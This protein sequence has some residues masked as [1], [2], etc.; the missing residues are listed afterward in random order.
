MFES[1]RVVGVWPQRTTARLSKG[2]IVCDRNCCVYSLSWPSLQVI[3]R[4]CS[5]LISCFEIERFSGMEKVSR[6]LCLVEGC[7]QLLHWQLSLSQMLGTT[8]PDTVTLSSCIL[9]SPL[10]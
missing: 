6:S 9:I 8:L 10:L 7:M 5:L 4:P 3:F 2:F 1:Q